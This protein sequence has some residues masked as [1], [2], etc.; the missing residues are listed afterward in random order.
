MQLELA[1]IHS[2]EKEAK[3]INSTTTIIPNLLD[4][5]K[6]PIQSLVQSVVNLFG[7]ADNALL[8]GQFKDNRREG[9]FPSE[10]S[11][12]VNT[13][14]SD[15]DFHK[16]STVAMA[17][18]EE[19]AK[20]EQFATGGYILFAA[21]KESNIDFL[22]VAMI[23]HR[24]GFQLDANFEP[25]DIEELD[26]SKLHQAARINFS[27][28][29][30]WRAKIDAKELLPEDEDNTYLS[31]VNRRA[32]NDTAGYFIEA[33]GCSKGISSAR[34]TS[35]ALS[36][37]KRYLKDNKLG[38]YAAKAKRKLEEFMYARNIDLP[39]SLDDLHF[40][41]AK[42]IP[43][44]KHNFL[45]NY[46]TYLNSEEG[47]VPATFEVNRK[48]LKPKIRISGGSDELGWHVDFDRSKLGSNEN[49]KVF[50]D[51]SKN[52]LTL[53]QLPKDMISSINEELKVKAESE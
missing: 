49:S 46:K 5:K 7:K 42:L 26:M 50:F 41:I 27:K 32:G 19:L 2:L 29:Q 12:Y 21:Y 51:S 37:T 14:H 39:V 48:T 30:S 25:K 6:K 40:E 15:A 4:V 20:E 36:A 18:L 3:S 31:F 24:S 34:A 17:E 1:V 10:F 16:L 23:K 9:E 43:V 52:T 11:N 13:G 28:Y 8:Y 45:E 35:N 33:L 22:L 53:S 44:E 38:D 47:K